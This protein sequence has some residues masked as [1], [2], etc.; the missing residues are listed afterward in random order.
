MSL[1]N[2]PQILP[3]MA[4]VI[5]RALVHSPD[6]RLAVPDLARGVSPSTLRVERETNQEGGRAFNLT[7]DACE[8]I[9]LIEVSDGVA[10]I[11]PVVTRCLSAKGEFDSAF[12][13]VLLDLV[14]AEELNGD[15]WASQEGARDLSRALAWWLA[16]DPRDPPAAWGR[17]DG[18]D[19]A[20]DRQFI[21]SDRLFSNG[22]RWGSFVRW[23]RFL[24]LAEE[25]S[26]GLIPDP[27]RAIRAVLNDVLEDLRSGGLLP[28]ADFLGRLGRRLPILDGG[29]YRKA[30]EERMRANTVPTGLA[31]SPAL[32][33]ALLRLRDERRVR[34]ESLADAPNRFFLATGFSPVRV[35]SHIA[36][37]EGVT[38][39]VTG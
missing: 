22:T 3:N 31:L 37:P 26:T 32:S 2:P 30:V 12:A 23:A 9:R 17:P 34:L 19:V 25:L 36:L 18:V 11:H 38:R 6:G 7:L 5:A 16:Q 29:P 1:L 28:V 35:I 14:L 13:S 27:T 4:L 21:N 39:M 10:R 33:H 24:G 8:R 15:L 20:Q